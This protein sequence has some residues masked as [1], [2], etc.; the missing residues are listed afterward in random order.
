MKK[1]VSKTKNPAA[2]YVVLFQDYCACF[3]ALATAP[4]RRTT[5]HRDG[6]LRSFDTFSFR[7]QRTQKA[8]SPPHP[9]PRVHHITPK[10]GTHFPNPS[11]LQMHTSTLSASSPSHLLRAISAR[12]QQTC[13]KREPRP[14]KK[15]RGRRNTKTRAE[16]KKAIANELLILIV[17]SARDVSAGFHAHAH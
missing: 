3:Q 2:L 17:I 15:R 8:S 5:I 11:T 9:L 16:K 7:E 14:R 6:V 12:P 13:D 1:E 10:I 4:D